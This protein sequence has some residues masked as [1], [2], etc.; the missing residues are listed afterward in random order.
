MLEKTHLA[1]QE[2]N[3]LVD[4]ELERLRLE[5]VSLKKQIDYLKSDLRYL[6]MINAKYL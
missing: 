4:N 2:F 6:E 5:V 1:D 3:H